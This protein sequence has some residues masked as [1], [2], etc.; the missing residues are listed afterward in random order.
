MILAMSVRREVHAPLGDSVGMLSFVFFSFIISFHVAWD[1][2]MMYWA[3]EGV[4]S[5]VVGSNVFD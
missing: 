4:V 3:I 5:R 2:I 1:W